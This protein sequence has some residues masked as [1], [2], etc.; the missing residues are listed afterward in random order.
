MRLECYLQRHSR[1]PTFSVSVNP[2]R[3]F[4]VRIYYYI[5]EDNMVTET[6]L[7]YIIR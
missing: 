3:S 6:L 5:A 2:F 1:S 4:V 7:G